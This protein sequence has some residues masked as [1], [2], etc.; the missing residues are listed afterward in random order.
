M[1]NKPLVSIVVPIYNVE[2][3]IEKC[4]DSILHQTYQN[5]EVILVNDGSTDNSRAIIEKYTVD[6]RCLIIDKVN[7]GLSS[8]RNA[9]I[10]VAHGKYM[11]FIDSDDYIE[12]IAVERLVERME[13]TFADFC[14][15]RIR[16]YHDDFFKLYGDSFSCDVL[17]SEDIFQD[18]VI[19]KNIKTTAWSKFFDHDFLK[20]NNLMFYEG[21]IN[22]D[23]LFTLQ[24]A[25]CAKKVVFLDVPLYNALQR[26]D[27]ISRNMKAA[28]LQV[29]EKIY[30]IMI[31]YMR[32]KNI[33]HQ[34]QSLLDLSLSNQLV[35]TITQAAYRFDTYDNFKN[36]YNLLTIYDYPGMK[37]KTNIS[38]FG[39]IKRLI[40][41]LS[42]YPRI[43]FFCIKGA[44]S[45]GF[46]MI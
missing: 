8:A 46:K 5:L 7:G 34:L 3:Y 29:Y 18:A 43:F 20:D 38:K 40:Y 33:L 28:N 2:D 17:T 39:K 45:V 11:Y 15:Y 10:R 35:Y 42:L 13:E 24:C 32:E 41:R 6:S 21:I 19:G 36:F 30:S 25:V 14:C 9:G 26:P 44:K 4:V 1:E 37:M 27:S 12:P 23:Y 31:E 22:E 16:F